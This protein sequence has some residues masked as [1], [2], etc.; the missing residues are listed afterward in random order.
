[1]VMARRLEKHLAPLQPHKSKETPLGCRLHLAGAALLHV[2]TCC[3]G[4]GRQISLSRPVKALPRTLAPSLRAENEY[5]SRTWAYK[6]LV[7]ACVVA[8]RVQH[9]TAAAMGHL[10]ARD[11]LACIRRCDT[12]VRFSTLGGLNID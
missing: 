4:R 8:P 1:M 5:G 2:A 3:S 7:G 9:D 6:N 10:G 12:F 11:T